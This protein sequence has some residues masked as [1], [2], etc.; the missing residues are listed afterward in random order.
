MPTNGTKPLPPWGPKQPLDHR[1]LNAFEGRAVTDI[2]AGPGL[3][4][5]RNGNTA[6]LGLGREDGTPMERAVVAMLTG[7]AT[8][9]GQYVGKIVQEPSTATGVESAALASLVNLPSTDDALIIHPPE[10]GTSDHELDPGTFAVG[11][12]VGRVE[13]GTHAGKLTVIIESFVEAAGVFGVVKFTAT[14]NMSVVNGRKIAATSAT[15]GPETVACVAGHKSG[16]TI[17]A[18]QPAGGTGVSGTTWLELG[19]LGVDFEVETEVASGTGTPT[20]PFFYQCKRGSS[21]F[22]ASAGPIYRPV[23]MTADAA[24]EFGRG[25]FVPGLDTFELAWVYETFSPMVPVLVATPTPGAGGDDPATTNYTIRDNVTHATIA[26]GVSH[27]NRPFGDTFKVVTG[28]TRGEGY[29]LT[30]GTFVLVNIFG[31]VYSTTPG[32]PPPP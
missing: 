7:E 30:D 14:A 5:A 11:R 3:I 8:A 18:A 4:Y 22:S 2:S 13:S 27:P 17:F 25:R 23:N 29:Y 16:D 6:I 15:T 32:C 24:A 21:V 12:I 26:T 9:G 19:P 10:I 20:D 28:G 1:R 31:E